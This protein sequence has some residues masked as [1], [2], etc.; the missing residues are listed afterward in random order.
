MKYLLPFK[1]SIC[2]TVHLLLD[3]GGSIAP[4]PLQLEFCLD[5]RE[6]N[7][8]RIWFC[9]KV[10]CVRNDHSCGPVCEVTKDRVLAGYCHPHCFSGRLFG[11]KE[12][13]ILP[14]LPQVRGFNC[15]AVS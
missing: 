6:K 12:E 2:L 8:D 3:S 9:S 4:T 1:L 5:E 15:E 7:S 10:W 11:S 13:K 14:K